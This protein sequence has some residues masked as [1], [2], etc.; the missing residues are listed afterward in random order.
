[1]DKIL[2]GAKARSFKVVVNEKNK[3]VRY[4][5]GYDEANVFYEHKIMK[6]LNPKTLTVFS[7]FIAKDDHAVYC[8]GKPLKNVDASSFERLNEYYAKDKNHG[9]TYDLGWIQP[10]TP[11]KLLVVKDADPATLKAFVKGKVMY[12][13]LA[14]DSTHVF[15]D[16]EI[17]PNA[18]PKNFDPDAW[19]EKLEEE[20]KGH[21]K[22]GAGDHPRL[23]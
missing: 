19:Y 21:T 8:S 10:P 4:N 20:S 23:G 18:D 3:K 17:I 6:G 1:M 2:L 12:D 5:W 16:G 14:V 13:N 11:C 22:T 7:P 9:Y 15:S